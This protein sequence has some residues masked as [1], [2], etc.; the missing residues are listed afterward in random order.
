MGQES[1]KQGKIV[2]DTT[3]SFFVFVLF[4]WLWWFWKGPQML[5]AVLWFEAG[6]GN[7]VLEQSEETKLQCVIKTSS[8]PSGLDGVSFQNN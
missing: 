1:S 4:Y 5:T 2:S 7:E 3:K 8:D 6:I